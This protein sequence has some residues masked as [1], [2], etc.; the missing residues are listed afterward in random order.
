M[1]RTP[2][3]VQASGVSFSGAIDLASIKA[4]YLNPNVPAAT[5]AQNLTADTVIKMSDTSLDA[6]RNRG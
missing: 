6:R 5:L 4:F 1:P 2:D 3:A